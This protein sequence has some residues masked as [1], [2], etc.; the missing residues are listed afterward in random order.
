MSSR[1]VY[2]CVLIMA[3]SGDGT[4]LSITIYVV[5]SLVRLIAAAWRRVWQ[6]LAWLNPVVIPGL[7]LCCPAWQ[8]VDC[9]ILIYSAAKLQV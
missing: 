5:I 9:V 4:T 8:L 3:L 7:L 1:P 2:R 6:L